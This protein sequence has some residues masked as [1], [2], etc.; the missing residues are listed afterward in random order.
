MSRIVLDTN[1]LVSFLTDRDPEQQARAAALFEDAAAGEVEIVL[2][3]MVIT[4]VVYVLGNLYKVDA[5]QIAQVLDDLLSLTGVRPVDEVVWTR[6][7]ELWPD[8]V[9]DFADAVLAAVTLE[10]RY[11][12]VAT[13]DRGFAKAL[14]R[15]GLE[16]C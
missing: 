8:Q 9:G 4:E 12:A 15:L 5:L 11:D 7:F 2:H 10:G 14:R 16:A 6:V 13:F 1:V 3:Q